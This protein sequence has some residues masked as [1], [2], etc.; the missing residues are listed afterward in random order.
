MIPTRPLADFAEELG[1]AGNLLAALAE[2][3]VSTPAQLVQWYPRRWEDRTR[4]DLWP[5]VGDGQP[6]CLL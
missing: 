2:E 6:V 1:L 5:T 4:F 3:G